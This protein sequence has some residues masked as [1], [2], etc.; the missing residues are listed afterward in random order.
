MYSIWPTVRVCQERPSLMWTVC[1]SLSILSLIKKVGIYRI[2]QNALQ[3]LD[4]LTQA[5]SLPECD[6]SHFPESV[7]TRVFLAAKHFGKC[8]ESKMNESDITD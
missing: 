6:S 4:M 1:P 8:R 3:I 7:L 2:D 5:L